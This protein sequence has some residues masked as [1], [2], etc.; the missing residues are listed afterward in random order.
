VLAGRFLRRRGT[1]VVLVQ[2]MYEDFHSP[3]KRLYNRLYDRILLGALLD[4]IHGTIFKTTAARA[5]LGGKGRPTGSSVVIPVGLDRDA[6]ETP[7]ELWDIAEDVRASVEV[8][9]SKR[10]LYIG[11]LEPRRRPEF[12]VELLEELVRED[13]SFAL[14]VVG[15]GPSAPTF[16]REVGAR[17]LESHV[18]MM[19]AVRQK[20]LGYVYS[21]C[22]LLLLP[23]R[24]EIFGMV[25]LEALNA[26]MA[27]LST[28]TAGATDILGDSTVSFVQPLEL[29]EWAETVRSYFQGGDLFHRENAEYIEKALTWEVL[30][31]RYLRFYEDLRNAESDAGEMR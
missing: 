23:S 6:L 26:G 20:D 31:P 17:G 28:P 8:L 18:V 7:E 12:L 27:V 5:Y 11:V 13:P 30:V 16:E 21:S 4:S 14:V 3:I 2:G 24:Y 9:G 15:D 1:T 19:G 25:L 10:L 22:G 29:R